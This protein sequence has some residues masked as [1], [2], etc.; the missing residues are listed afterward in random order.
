MSRAQWTE[1][2]DRTEWDN[3]AVQNGASVFHMWPWRKVLEE[4]RLRPLYL[5]CYDAEGRLVAI[6]PFFYQ[7]TGRRL[8]YLDSLPASHMAGPVISAQATNISQIL[9]L[10]RKSVKFSPL[11][12]VISMQIR[13]HQQP[14]IQPLIALGFQYATDG[15]FILD[16][17]KRTPSYIWNEGFQKHDRQAVKFYEQ[18]GSIFGFAR[19]EDEYADFWTLHQELLQRKGESSR[20]TD[21]LSAMRTN[22]G[23][24][25]RVVTVSLEGKMIAGQSLICDPRNSIVHFTVS[26]YSRSKNIHSPSVYLNHKIISWAS[27]NGFRYVNFGPAS[28]DPEDPIGKSK[29]KF[30]GER[31]ERYRFTMPTSKISYSLARKIDRTLRSFKSQ[32]LSSDEK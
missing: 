24:Q 19:Q 5:S 30:C 18:R 1:A 25:F 3:F 29:E 7:K 17:H 12:P 16:L 23:E 10:L 31:I 22:F 2:R 20:Y 13:T 27:E 6:C 14:I 28:L 8:Q 15:L 11:N 9:E 21:F 32:A 4:S 26:G